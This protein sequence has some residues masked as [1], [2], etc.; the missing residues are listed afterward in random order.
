MKLVFI[1]SETQVFKGKDGDYYMNAHTSNAAL[2]EYKNLCDQLTL[3]FRYMGEIKSTQ[4]LVKIDKSIGNLILYPN[5]YTLKSFLNIKKHFILRNIIREIIKE[6]DKVICGT[7]CGEVAKVVTSAC[8]DYN[9]PYLVICLGMMFEGLWHHSW[10]GKLLA[11]PRE[12]ICIETFRNAPYALYVTQEACQKRYPC[13]GTSLGCS[14]VELEEF[15]IK[16]LQ[17][18]LEKI[19]KEKKKIIIG[20]AAF[21]DV[22]WKGQHLVLYAIKNL[23]K[24]GY[25]IEYQLIGKGTGIAIQNLAKKLGVQNNITILGALPHNKVFQWYDSIDIYIQPSYQEGLCRSIIEAMSR[26]CPVICSNTGGN[27]ELIDKDFLF[28]TGSYKALTETLKKIISE[29]NMLIQAQN[30]F[31]KSKVYNIHSLREKRINF[32]KEFINNA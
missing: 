29:D 16:T 23:I 17:Q 28:K 22:K 7:S 1:N 31:E 13:H 6:S 2:M 26:A 19:K 8:K 5:T 27:Y 20:T 12:R 3:V 18:R 25:D 4:G 15:N 24:Q 30:N 11:F 21:L 9:K 14:D 10:K 32:L